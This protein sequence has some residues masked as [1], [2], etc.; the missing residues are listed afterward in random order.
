MSDRLADVWRVDVRC[1]RT[2][3][4]TTHWSLRIWPYRG[5]PNGIY[6]PFNPNVS[7]SELARYGGDVALDPSPLRR[8]QLE[9]LGLAE[10]RCDRCV[11]AIK[12]RLR[13]NV[14]F[15]RPEHFRKERLGRRR[16]LPHAGRRDPETEWNAYP[17]L[18]RTAVL[19]VVARL[20]CRPRPGATMSH[21]TWSRTGHAARI[22]SLVVHL[23]RPRSPARTTTLRAHLNPRLKAVWNERG[24]RLR[25][26]LRPR[27]PHS[28]QPLTD[29]SANGLLDVSHL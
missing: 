25:G 26:L 24:A 5:N 14:E 9:R 19:S 29:R 1:G 18:S 13:P 4:P 16:P 6:V 23:V 8:R 2:P 17:T 15:V 12:E 10:R 7:C 27:L 21:D 20:P 11:Q 3:L 22:E 28:D